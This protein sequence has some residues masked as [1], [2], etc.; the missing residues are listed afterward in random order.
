MLRFIV[1][2]CLPFSILIFVYVSGK[3]P[4]KLKYL[5]NETIEKIWLEMIECNLLSRKERTVL[6]DAISKNINSIEIYTLEYK[7]GLKI[8]AFIKMVFEKCNPFVITTG[9][10][11]DNILLIDEFDFLKE[12]KRYDLQDD[13]EMKVSSPD[14]F[15]AFDDIKEKL[16]LDV[17]CIK[18][19]NEEY[20]CQ[21]KFTLEKKSFIITALI[22]E[23]EF[24]ILG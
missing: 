3:T 16:L 4:G 20:Y 5:L 19:P 11:A 12:K 1:S 23:L 6:Q 8:C 7:E 14:N 15:E 17:I 22:D 9:K 10:F 24:S 18:K 2:Q 13:V 21:F